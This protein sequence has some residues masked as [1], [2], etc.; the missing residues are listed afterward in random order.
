M[1]MT[2]LSSLRIQMSKQKLSLH[3]C[4]AI[5]PRRGLKL[6][7]DLVMRS[8]DKGEL[9]VIVAGSPEFHGFLAIVHRFFRGR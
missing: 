3:I 4:L 1:E 2:L 8:R 5:P 6:L 9:E 7:V